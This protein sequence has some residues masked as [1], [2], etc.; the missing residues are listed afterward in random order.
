MWMTAVEAMVRLG[1]TSAEVDEDIALG[2]LTAKR[3]GHL[4][5]VDLPVERPAPKKRRTK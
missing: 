2:V 4:V 3:E 5:L 1:Q